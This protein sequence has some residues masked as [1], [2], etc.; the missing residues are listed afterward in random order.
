MAQHP[1]VQPNVGDGFVGQGVSLNPE[2]PA[3][4][5]R[6]IMT[7]IFISYAREDEMRVRE[8]VD[9]LEESAGPSFGTGVF[10]PEK[11]GKAILAKP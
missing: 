9:A 3:T 4:D 2:V 5:W 1:S 7:D 8:L 11:P 6:G 10:P